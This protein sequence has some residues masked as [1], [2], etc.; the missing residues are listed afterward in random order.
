[1]SFPPTENYEKLSQK[2]RRL[3]IAGFYR[4]TLA[5][6][7]FFV[8]GGCSQTATIN[9]QPTAASTLTPTAKPTLQPTKTSEVP[10]LAE[11]GINE[12]AMIEKFQ[13][14]ET[15]VTREGSGAYSVT[16]TSYVDLAEDAGFEKTQNK[17][18][19][20]T[21][22]FSIHEDLNNAYAPATVEAKNE[23][24]EPVTLIWNEKL[25]WIEEFELSTDVLNPTDFP[26]EARVPM[27]QSILL[28]HEDPFEERSQGLRIR[29]ER[30]ENGR[31]VYLRTDHFGN[32]SK[33]TE[34]WL[35]V[36]MPDGKSHYVNP[37]DIN[38]L[39]GRKVQMCAYGENMTAS[40]FQRGLLNIAIHQTDVGSA[41]I[42]WPVLEADPSVLEQTQIRPRIGITDQTDLNYL[43]TLNGNKFA[44]ELA[45]FYLT[46]FDFPTEDTTQSSEI[47]SAIVISDQDSWIPAPFNPALQ[48]TI[49]PCDIR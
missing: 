35:R 11:L 12:P 36:I 17:Y 39:D 9:T 20:D 34:Y 44:K 26:Y 29:S 47:E 10:T 32:Q 19:I 24:N 33:P 31:V 21:S 45:S 15:S 23:E 41:N 14:A 16:A 1:M 13:G 42:F 22:S 8:A 49:L 7:A 3:P 40:I 48:E 27:V 28:Q 2:R 5:A 37:V 4:F 38:D 46:H 25:G 30:T 43:L 18:T 6:L